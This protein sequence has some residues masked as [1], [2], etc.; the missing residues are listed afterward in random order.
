MEGA[1]DERDALGRGALR[2]I[3]CEDIATT[4]G[5]YWTFPCDSTTRR[6]A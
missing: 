1:H 3:P 5:T 6:A 4:G 2:P